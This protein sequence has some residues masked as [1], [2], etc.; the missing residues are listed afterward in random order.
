MNFALN[1]IQYL[2]ERGLSFILIKQIN[3]IQ[4]ISYLIEQFNFVKSIICV[5]KNK[6]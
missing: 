2:L 3:Q 5:L 6:L 4:E 1:V